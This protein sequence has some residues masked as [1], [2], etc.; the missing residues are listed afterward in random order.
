MA[1]PAL[2]LV[3]NA[4]LERQ[5]MDSGECDAKLWEDSLEARK[6]NEVSRSLEK[7]KRDLNV[8][9]RAAGYNPKAPLGRA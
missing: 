9:S 4:E 6:W 5:L 7:I 8:L 3:R 2:L 1:A